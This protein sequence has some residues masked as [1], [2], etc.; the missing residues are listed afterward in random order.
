M[1]VGVEKRAL[2]IKKHVTIEELIED[3]IERMNHI[4]DHLT[5]Y[6]EKVR[7]ALQD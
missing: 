1:S 3:I 6:Q 4:G 2:S 7:K 5:I